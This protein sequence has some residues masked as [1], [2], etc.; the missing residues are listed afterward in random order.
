MYYLGLEWPWKGNK[1]LSIV[2]IFG[3]I[4]ICCHGHMSFKSLG[5]IVNEVDDN[6]HW[7]AA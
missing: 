2:R 3:Y 7:S 5:Q 6:V 4:G 1:Y